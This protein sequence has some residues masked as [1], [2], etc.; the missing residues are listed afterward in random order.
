MSWQFWTFA[1]LA[2]VL[3]GGVAWYERSRPP[4]QV[5]ALVAALAALAVAGRLVLAPIPNAV[6]TTDIVLI[7]GYALGPAPGFMVG[8]LAGL[9]SNFWLG[10]GPWTPWQMAA[11]GVVG[12]GGAFLATFFTTR[13]RRPSRIGRVPLAL[14]CGVAGI[15][16]GAIMNFSI[17]A[18]YGGDVSLARFLALSA[19]AVPFDVTHALGNFILALIAG[20]AMLRML[21]RFRDRFRWQRA[22]VGAT[23]AIVAAFVLG[24]GFLIAPGQARA[25]DL[26]AA[27]GWMGSVQNADGGFGPSP[28]DESSVVTTSWA[29]LGLAAAGVNAHDLPGRNGA[30]PVDFLRKNAG[31]VTSTGDIA[32]TILAFNSAGEDPRKFSGRNLITELRGR[33]KK[34]GSWE[35]W[36]NATAIAVIGLRQSGSTGGL[37]GSVDWLREVQNEDGG[38]GSRPDVFSDSDSTGNVL[39]VIGGEKTVSSALA[40]LRKSHRPS[41]GFPLSPGAPVNTQST[42]WAIQGLVAAG[43]NPKGFTAGGGKSPMQFLDDRQQDDGHFRYSAESDQTPV[44]VTAQAL[45]AAAGKSFP[46]AA[47]PREPEPEPAPKPKPTPQP[48]PTP[49]PSPAPVPSPNPSPSLPTFPSSGSNSGNGSNGSRGSSNGSS[50]VKPRPVDPGAFDEPV[51]SPPDAD[52]PDPGADPGSSLGGGLEEE[53]SPAIA[54]DTGSSEPVAERRPAPSAAGPAGIGLGLAALTAGGMWF[55]GRRRGW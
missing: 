49:Q 17:M 40:F 48:A 8:A 10:Q 44:W 4:S 45:V 25:A 13:L 47:P 27:I 1:V 3:A 39:Q 55:L 14:V 2:V 34:D 12:I 18:T 11:W 50:N 31:K 38:W 26:D 19:R 22:T 53:G 9:V 54:E 21:E 32:R 16:F 24:S 29:I 15:F 33:M 6:A 5:V 7:A 30:D 46:I 36:P 52:V 20:P 37:K 41:G 35:G 23:L 42:A 51:Q 28:G 43:I